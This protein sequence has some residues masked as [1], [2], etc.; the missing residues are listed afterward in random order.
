MTDPADLI[1]TSVIETTDSSVKLTSRTIICSGGGDGRAKFHG[2][3]TVYSETG[4][5]Y[6]SI[7]VVCA[8]GD[9]TAEMCLTPDQ[10][11]ALAVAIMM[12]RSEIMTGRR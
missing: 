1:D 5:T 2:G 12:A 10:A 7:G 11:Y 8:G 4:D 6:I 3:T 9:A